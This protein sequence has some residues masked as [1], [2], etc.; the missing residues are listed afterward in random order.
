[1]T[2]A[3]T[4]RRFE[5]LA[6][7][8]DTEAF[9]AEVRAWL[10]AT[11]PADWLAT[12]TGGGEQAYV[13][14]QRWWFRELMKVGLATAHWP[15]AWGGEELPLEYQ[16]VM[17]E[18]FGK[19]RAPR[20]LLYTVSLYH[21]PATLFAHG[22][23]EQRDRFLTGVRERGELWCQGFSEPGAGSDLAS[24]RTRAERKVKPDGSVVYVVNG[25]KV[26]SSFGMH[27]DYYML[28]ARTDPDAPKKQAGISFFLLPMDTPGLIR[29][30]IRQINGD[31]E[32]C[33]V[34]LDDVEIPAENLIGR[35]NEGWAIAQ[36]TLSAE[37]G[38]IIVDQAQRMQFVLEGVL[39]DARGGKLAWW[40]D[41]DLRRQ[42]L[43]LYAQAVAVRA[44]VD[45]MIDEIVHNPHMGTSPTPTLV[46]LSYSE[47]LRRYTTFTLKRDGLAAQVA[48]PK[49]L[50]AGK[51]TENHM[52]DYLSAYSWTIS[53]GT[54]EVLK[55]V[56]AERVL[57]LPR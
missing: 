13:D 27:A 35:E 19:V 28:L 18:E 34:F 2:V 10:A 12:I 31:A 47:L 29:R 3:T 48:R 55:N 7:L 6:K 32:F 23:P 37:R 42:F 14:F 24:L 5:P 25:Q 40:R 49:A 36:S 50:G 51:L 16:V 26:W 1:M 57:G 22:T 11:L 43:R 53:G 46:K 45:R 33:E 54:N 17:N 39:A 56:L 20:P 15:K 8:G 44:L 41:V 9:R 30:P 4:E 52:D 38:L 21:L